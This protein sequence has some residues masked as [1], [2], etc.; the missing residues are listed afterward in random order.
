MTPPETR[1]P[2]KP[3]GVARIF[4]GGDV[5]G[6][7]GLE[8]VLTLLPPLLENERV[9]F[10]IVN[11]ENTDCGSGI[12][13]EQARALFASGV[14]VIT[15]GNHSFEK[16]HLWPVFDEFGAVIRPGNF[17]DLDTISSKEWIPR[18]MP[19]GAEN[20]ASSGAH[21]SEGDPRAGQPDATASGAFPGRG[22]VIVRK[23]IGGVPRELC[24]INVQGRE[25]LRP[26]GC[27]FRYTESVLE[28]LPRRETGAEKPLP[29]V[30]D[31]HG[32]SNG[33]KEAFCLYFDGKLSAVTGTHTH[34]QTADARILPGGT[35]CI[36]DLGMCGPVRSVIGAEPEDSVWKALTQTSRKMRE[37]RGDMALRGCII[38]IDLET[39]KAVSITTIEK[40]HLPADADAP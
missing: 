29:V 19:A 32:E 27:P 35:A 23:D 39:A 2:V 3:G 11:G 38:D 7:G 13:A 37:A 26:I 31:F 15:G 12:T 40:T 1:I 21:S 10:C 28:T 20:D 14:D 30:V 4:S 9:D 18:L 22:F 24:V 6:A 5:F 16:R 34:V 8:C 36:S 33:E 17:P 25:F